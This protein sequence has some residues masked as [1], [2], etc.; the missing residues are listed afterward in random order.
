M[1]QSLLRTRKKVESEKEKF[2]AEMALKHDEM[3]AAAEQAKMEMDKHLYIHR[4]VMDIQKREIDM[5]LQAIITQMTQHVDE[6]RKRFLELEHKL[7]HK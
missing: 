1:I 3:K 2:A 6:I 7:K 4:D 5:K